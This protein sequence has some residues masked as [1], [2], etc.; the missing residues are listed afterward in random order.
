MRNSESKRIFQFEKNSIKILVLQENLQSPNNCIENLKNFPSQ[1]NSIKNEV[2]EKIF[3]MGKCVIEK[4]WHTK[5]VYICW[6]S[7]K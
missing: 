6:K 3:Q 2:S 1:N 7:C 5:N 4:M